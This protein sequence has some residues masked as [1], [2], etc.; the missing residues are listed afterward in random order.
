VIRRLLR[1]AAAASICSAAALESPARAQD[2]GVRAAATV[3]PGVTRLGERVSYRGRVVGTAAIQ[4][5]PPEAHPSLTWGKPQVGRVKGRGA[6]TTWIE[7]PLQSFAL[8]Q[9]VIPGL[10]FRTTADGALHRLPQVRL[11]VIATLDPADSNA[12][13]RPLRT[14]AAPWWERIPWLWVIVGLVLLA[15][16]VLVWRRLR[17]RRPIAAPAPVPVT[18]RRDPAAEAL[19]ALADLRAM[20]LPEQ[21]RFAEHAFHLGQILRRYLEATVTTTRPGDSTPELVAHLR[22]AQLDAADLER[23]SGALRVWDR[24]KFAREPFTLDEAHRTETAVEGFVRRGLAPTRREA[25]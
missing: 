15:V 18:T 14:L 19:K 17:R 24:V 2:A 25:A 21:G 23:L 1:V 6:D 20:R 3:T 8:G 22:E 13:L 4:W 9:T 12:T 11:D 5:L 7:V 16:A 10:Q